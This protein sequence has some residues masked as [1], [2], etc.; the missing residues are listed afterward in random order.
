MDHQ[1]E[2]KASICINKQLDTLVVILSMIGCKW[3]EQQVDFN[4]LPQPAS[5]QFLE[6][7]VDVLTLVSHYRV[8]TYTPR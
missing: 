2:L 1:T 6:E 8:D 7:L 3:L 4:M 5:T